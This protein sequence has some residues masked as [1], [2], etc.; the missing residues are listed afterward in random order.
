[1]KNAQIRKNSLYLVLDNI[2]SVLNVGSILRTSDAFGVKIVYVCGYTATID[3]EKLSKTALGAENSVLWEQHKQTWRVLE[4][5]KEQGVLIIALEQ[6]SKS[7]SLSSYKIPKN[8]KEIAIIVGNEV[9]GL[10][11][12][13]LKF[14]DAVI[15]IPM[16][17]I[18]ESLNVAVATG[19]A[20]FSLTN[21]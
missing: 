17:G 9:N 20:L 4:K 7:V 18:K 10:S 14:A 11:S 3:K 15:E 19:I 8:K 5:L 13:I 2:R 6:N 21:D 12:A 1:M 16:R